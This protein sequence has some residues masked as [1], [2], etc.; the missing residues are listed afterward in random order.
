MIPTW[1]MR[2]MQAFAPSLICWTTAFGHST[3]STLACFPKKEKVDHD[4]EL[5]PLIEMEEGTGPKS[6]STSQEDYGQ[7]MREYALFIWSYVLKTNYIPTLLRNFAMSFITKTVLTYFQAQ[8]FASAITQPQEVRFILGLLACRIISLVDTTFDKIRNSR[9]EMRISREFQLT[10]FHRKAQVPYTRRK[11]SDIHEL[12]T[13][14]SDVEEGVINVMAYL[15]QSFISMISDA[16][17]VTTL[18]IKSDLLWILTLVSLFLYATIRY[19][20]YPRMKENQNKREVMKERRRE[21]NGEAQM[22]KFGFEEFPE[23]F[24]HFKQI[25]ESE[26]K[27]FDVRLES[28]FMNTAPH[29]I[30]NVAS[31]LS[32]LFILGYTY[33]SRTRNYFIPLVIVP[34]LFSLCTEAIVSVVNMEETI[35]KYQ[36][37]MKAYRAKD[38]DLK[39]VEKQELQVLSYEPQTQLR[40]SIPLYAGYTLQTPTNDPY[41][42]FRQE[43]KIF[44]TGA[45]GQGKT[46]LAE[47]LSGRNYYDSEYGNRRLCTYY[48]PQDYNKTWTQRPY[49]ISA[50]FPNATPEEVIKILRA[51]Q[52][53]LQKLSSYDEEANTIDLSETFPVMSGGELKRLQYAILMTRDLTP[54]HQMIIL[55]EPHKELD[56][57]TASKMVR[58]IESLYPDRTMVVIQHQKPETPEFAHWREWHIEGGII[59]DI[60]LPTSA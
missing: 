40:V 29:T 30:T 47:K 15:F 32:L 14:E 13:L 46:T 19:V 34:Q 35:E 48:L 16:I 52:Y 25:Q 33:V 6:Q 18:F 1:M 60:T 28:I 22:L 50:V 51:F 59:R 57:E 10:T 54:A 53:P 37:Y 21:I 42:T 56:L 20:V 38:A 49:K 3:L 55:D 5:E 8:L 45:S 36:E 2:F 27:S 12:A 9:N 43:D 23:K 17:I 11:E 31:E 4:I 44:I 41:L 24:E 7:V 39:Q 58:G 26:Q